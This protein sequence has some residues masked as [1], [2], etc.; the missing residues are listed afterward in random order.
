M[1]INVIAMIG[2]GPLIT[3]P[4][5]LGALHGPLSLIGWLLGALLALCD[6]MVWAELGSAYPRSGGTYQYL[7][8][9]F[10][11]LRLGRLLAF[12]FVWQTI[13]VAPLTLASGY[14]GF[15]NY[16]GYFIPQLAASPFALKALAIGV[17]ILTIIALYRGITAV[18]R[19]GA[20]LAAV[21][22]FT[23]LCVIAAAFVHWSPHLATAMPVGDSFWGGLRAGLGQALIIAMYD[24]LGYNQANYLGDEVREPA[25]TLPRAILISVVLVAALYIALQVG[26]LGAIP[27]QSIVPLADGSLPPLAQ[28]LASVLVERAFGVP[29]AGAVTL[30]ILVT[31]FASV[32]G[33]LLGASRVP[34]AAACDGNFLRSFA[35]VHEKLRIPDISLLVIGAVALLACLFTLDQVI[36]ALTTG[37]VLIQ[38]I[39][40][41][42]A[43][44]VLR[45]K[46]IRAPYR[47]WLFPIPALLALAGWIYVFASAGAPA[48]LFGLGTLLAGLAVFYATRRAS[49]P[50]P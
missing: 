38:S 47:M 12:L 48:I 42:A 33:N 14:I 21:A 30:L 10:G 8:D 36:N 24:Y 46:K 4:L 28:H 3:I 11:R 16:V 31:A 22:I 49:H 9:I 17:G 45:S 6:G 5:V 32:Y 25:K 26:V 34:Y 40:Q 7:L 13:F 20:W 1:A 18:A 50:T 37:I 41:I 43:L 2:I 44:F 39:A 15:S 23:L 27:W 19:I 35:H 29:I